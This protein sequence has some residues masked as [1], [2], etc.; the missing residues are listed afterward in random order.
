MAQE[1]EDISTKAGWNI[2]SYKHYRGL[3]DKEMMETC[4]IYA[5]VELGDLPVSK[6]KEAKGWLTN[7]HR[8]VEY[9]REHIGERIEKLRV[10][11]ALLYPAPEG[12]SLRCHRRRT[13][14][15]V[16]REARRAGPRPRDQ[17]EEAAARA[18]LQAAR[19]LV[20]GGSGF[21]LDLSGFIR[22]IPI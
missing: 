8:E 18:R 2:W 13:R 11:Q 7:A 17:A 12:A 20:C 15:R 1:I 19:R 21:I 3:L 16:L 6:G 14:G 10:S 22:N 5:E 4:R 9:A